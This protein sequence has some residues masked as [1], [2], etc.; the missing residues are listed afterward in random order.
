MKKHAISAVMCLAA[1]VLSDIPPCNYSIP[2]YNGV[3]CNELPPPPPAPLD[4]QDCSYY[5]CDQNDPCDTEPTIWTKKERKRDIKKAGSPV[6][7]YD[8]GIVAPDF[9]RGCCH[10]YDANE[11][12]P[13]G[14]GEG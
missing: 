2:E 6:Q 11:D 4:A 1:L 12:P 8:G 3:P 9:N 10:C 14:G 13:G 5:F 7:F